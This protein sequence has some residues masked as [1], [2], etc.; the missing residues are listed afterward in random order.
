MTLFMVQSWMC[1]FMNKNL[2][3]L[4]LCGGLLGCTENIRTRSFGGDMTIA[5]P[6]G[7]KLVSASW[8]TET[9]W[10]LYRPMNS[11][12][13]ATTSIYAEKSNFGL[14]QGKVIFVESK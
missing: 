12:E 5:L 7:Q 9:L 2:L 4:V 13:V 6:P 10:Y 14:V 3:L 11:N 8:K 1:N